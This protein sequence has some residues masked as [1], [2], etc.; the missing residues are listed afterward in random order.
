METSER[1]EVFIFDDAKSEEDAEKLLLF[2]NFLKEHFVNRVMLVAFENL[3]SK[4]SDDEEEAVIEEI[5]V[6]EDNFGNLPII[7]Y[8]G[9]YE[10]FLCFQCFCGWK[11]REDMEWI[12]DPWNIGD[13]KQALKG[14][15][16]R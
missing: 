16:R 12:Q 7:F 4:I 15:E 14:I 10:E 6:L 8:G 3:F 13:L 5:F 2:R 9:D 11:D 1:N